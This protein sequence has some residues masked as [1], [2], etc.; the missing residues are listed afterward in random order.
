M[1]HDVLIRPMTADDV[2]TAEEIS[3]LAF[4]ELDRRTFPPSWPAPDRPTPE[5]SARWVAKTARLLEHDPGG[6]WVAEDATGVVG[7]ATSLRREEV[8]CLAT[9]AVR[10]GRQGK[11]IGRPLLEA[12]L[13][14]GRDCPRGLLSASMDPLAARRYRLAGFGL[15]PQMH[16][17][18]TVDRSVLPAVTGLREGDASDFELLDRIDRVHRGGGHGPDHA[19]LLESGR[20]VVDVAGRGYAYLAGGRV[21]LVAALEEDTAARLLWHCLAT[22]EGEAV[23]AHVTGAN[24]WAVE[25][26]I[27]A[28][29][30]LGQG[31]Y[32]GVRGMTPPS[33]YVHNGALL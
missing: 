31:G 6:C 27:R 12:A 11:G 28:R 1:T 16:L 4:H 24:Q 7:F 32:L 9:Y 13:S 18:G 3:D 20:L 30:E 15:H 33:P 25:I 5:H 23:L 29:L 10:P 2:T 17:R 21:E 26:G 14:H 22:A 19:S 8:W